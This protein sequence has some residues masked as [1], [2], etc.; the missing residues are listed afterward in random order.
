MWRALG[1]PLV[2]VAVVAN[3]A[4]MPADELVER[5][6]TTGFI[7]R[8]H[9]VEHVQRKPRVRSKPVHA[10]FVELLKL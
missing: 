10:N 4:A 5:W 8:D 6:A 3:P 7:V 9:L 2:D 1:S